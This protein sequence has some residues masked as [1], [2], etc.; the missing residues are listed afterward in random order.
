MPQP[1]GHGRLVDQKPI[2]AYAL[3]RVPELVKIHRLLDVTIGAQV[4]ALDQIALFLGAGQNDD[5]DGFCPLI[6]LQAL[7]HFHAVHLG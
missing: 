2:H 5:W 4:V 3:H 1:V 7:E 6:R